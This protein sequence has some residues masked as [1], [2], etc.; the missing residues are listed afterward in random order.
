MMFFPFRPKRVALRLVVGLPAVSHPPARR[1][2][3]G[4][5]YIRSFTAGQRINQKL[6][7]VSVGENTSTLPDRSPFPARLAILKFASR[8]S[9]VAFR[10][11]TTSILKDWPASDV[12]RSLGVSLANVYV[13]KRRIAAALKTTMKSLE[14]EIEKA[15]R[16]GR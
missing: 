2:G 3:K 9:Q 10:A 11:T 7:R 15:L 14:R 1:N 13:T 6:D 12:A 4:R 5:F 8:K 16:A